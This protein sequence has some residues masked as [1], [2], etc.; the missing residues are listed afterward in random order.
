MLYTVYKLYMV[1]KLH[2]VTTEE[3]AAPI[4][5]T[6]YQLFDKDVKHMNYFFLFMFNFP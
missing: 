6:S 4:T 2:T 1:D 3:I 5:R